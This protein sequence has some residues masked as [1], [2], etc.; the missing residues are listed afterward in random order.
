MHLYVIVLSS[1]FWKARLELLG[2]S[3]FSHFPSFFMSYLKHATCEPEAWLRNLL[4]KAFLRCCERGP[5]TYVYNVFRRNAWCYTAAMTVTHEQKNKIHIKDVFPIPFSCCRRDHNFLYPHSRQPS[6]YTDASDE[7]HF[8]S[9]LQ[10]SHY[11]L[12]LKDAD[13]TSN[14]TVRDSAS[15]L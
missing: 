5:V 2:F 8:R 3:F 12:C 10:Y 7:R 13:C 9:F 6:N 1:F 15:R 4:P 14:A 11:V